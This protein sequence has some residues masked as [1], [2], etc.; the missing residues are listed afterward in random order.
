MN[1]RTAASGGDSIFF[2][3]CKILN[4]KIEITSTPP[5]SSGNP[6]LVLKECFLDNSVAQMYF[7]SNTTGRTGKLEVRNSDFTTTCEVRI[8]NLFDF[9]TAVFDN[10]HFRGAISNVEGG[11]IAITETNAITPQD[12][13][14]S[15]DPQRGEFTLELDSPLINSGSEGQT[16]GGFIVGEPIDLSV[17]DEQNNLNI[18]TDITIVSGLSG[19]VVKTIVFDT[20]IENLIINFNGNATSTS[21]PDSEITTSTPENYTFRA[22]TKPSSSSNFTEYNKFVY[23]IPMTVDSNGVGNG[24][25]NFDALTQESLPIKEAIFDFTFS[26]PELATIFNSSNEFV[27]GEY[28]QSNREGRDG[29][30]PLHTVPVG[31]A[32]EW[33]GTSKIHLTND[34]GGAQG[35]SDATY[36]ADEVFTNSGKIPIMVENATGGGGF[37]SDSGGAAGNHWGATGNL[38]APAKTK[39]D[40]AL[41][42][43]G[44]TIPL[45]IITGGERDAQQMDSESSYTKADAKAAFQDFINR[46]NT[47]YPGCIIL[48]TE[49]GQLTTG[50]TTGWQDFRAIQ[51]ETAVEIANVYISFDRA[52]FFP[53]EGKMVDSIHY[54]FTG[55]DEM[56]RANAQF[57]ISL[58]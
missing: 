48:V 58:I 53:F 42:D 52:K 1:I 38:Y 11:S 50:D 17:S 36:F 7:D 15:G 19:N 45:I 31:T 32:F 5:L 49:L 18:G 25:S 46:L 28:S 14:Y 27:V 13:R 41:A 30:S 34:R 26:N 35:G 12:P 40:S 37:G 51:Q 24:D 23:G 47:D 57:F 54:N 43:A 56:G 3:K 39:L 9:G 44:T 10:N 55:N 33:T 21:T 22:R 16:V 29:D 2:A 6:N 4:S 8:N 20:I